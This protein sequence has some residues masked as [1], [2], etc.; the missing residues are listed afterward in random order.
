VT[1]HGFKVS[2]KGKWVLVEVYYL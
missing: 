2:T 1:G